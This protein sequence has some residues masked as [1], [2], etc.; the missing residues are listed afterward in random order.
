MFYANK[1]VVVGRNY[2]YIT[3]SFSAI[4]APC[5]DFR[6]ILQI[7]FEV[8][9]C[10]FVC[11]LIQNSNKASSSKHLDILFTYS[12]T[13]TNINKSYAFIVWFLAVTL[14][15]TVSVSVQPLLPTLRSVTAEGCTS[16]GGPRSSVVRQS[17][18]HALLFLSYF[19]SV[20]FVC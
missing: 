18:A 6:A 3:I 20:V 17:S 12:N 9:M 14:V 2:S 11:V 4:L 10:I 15:E 8:C 5:T 19:L 13:V 16:A 1:K 7:H